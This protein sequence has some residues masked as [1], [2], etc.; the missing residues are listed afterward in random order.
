MQI[1]RERERERDFRERERR[2]G[3]HC[4]VGE[5]ERERAELI[6]KWSFFFSQLQRTI[7]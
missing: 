4:R 2:G 6:I 1:L 5:R 7:C 3:R